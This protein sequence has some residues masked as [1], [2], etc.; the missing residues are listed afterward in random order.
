ME[1][2]RHYAYQ[3]CTPTRM[4]FLSGRLPVHTPFRLGNYCNAKEGIP[5]EMQGWLIQGVLLGVPHDPVAPR[6]EPS[7]RLGP[8]PDREGATGNAPALVPGPLARL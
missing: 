3:V 8:S 7:W 2:D 4:S 1:L 5:R 6:G